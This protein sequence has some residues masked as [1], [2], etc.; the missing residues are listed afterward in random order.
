MVCTRLVNHLIVNDVELDGDKLENMK[1]FMGLD[2]LTN[3]LRLQIAKDLVA[4]GNDSHKK[5]MNIQEVATVL[6]SSGGSWF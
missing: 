1:H 6:L 4:S 2:F 5:L 3:E